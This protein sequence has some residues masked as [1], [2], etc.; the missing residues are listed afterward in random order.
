MTKIFRKTCSPLVKIISDGQNNF[1]QNKYNK[2]QKISV[3][4]V[5]KNKCKSANIGS[6]TVQLHGVDQ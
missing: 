4:V 5:T 3:F 2:L 6:S 1:K